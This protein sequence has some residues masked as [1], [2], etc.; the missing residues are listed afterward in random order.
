M[1]RVIVEC[2]FPTSFLLLVEPGASV[3]SVDRPEL[4]ASVQTTSHC[5]SK[6]ILAILRVVQLFGSFDGIRPRLRHF[7]PLLF[8]NVRTIETDF[9]V[10]IGSQAVTDTFGFRRNPIE[11]AHWLRDIRKIVIP[12]GWIF[13]QIWRQ[14]CHRAQSMHRRPLTVFGK[15]HV[16]GIALRLHGYLNFRICLAMGYWT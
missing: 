8:K 14:V 10:A 15:D 11:R 13:I 9:R 5:R 3:G 7:Y 12:P 4:P 6:A 2:G 1:A 16:E